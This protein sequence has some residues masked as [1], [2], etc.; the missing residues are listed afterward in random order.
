MSHLH[1]ILV[2]LA[3]A[4]A[5]ARAD[6]IM[7]LA[8]PEHIPDNNPLGITQTLEVSG[9]TDPIASVSVVL[10]IS[11]QSGGAFNGDFFVSLLHDSGYAVLLNRAGRTSLN[12]FGYA[13]NGFNVTFTSGAPDV[14]LYQSVP[15]T[16]GLAGELTGTWGEDGRA[17]YPYVTTDSDS[18]T[19]T[20]DSF[21]GLD[22]NGTWTL[23][24]AD[25]SGN[26]NGSVESWGIEL[27]VVPEPA[28]ILLL[29]LGLSTMVAWNRRMGYV[30]SVR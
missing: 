18:R 13:D 28:S 29:A 22:P 9:Y 2:L 20:L 5:P 3:V 4:V 24:V 15:Y 6:L 12:P 26:G 17:T 25:I 10:H 21:A 1:I 30:H 23:F 7:S 14:H 19:A 11:G 27:T 8:P 16:L